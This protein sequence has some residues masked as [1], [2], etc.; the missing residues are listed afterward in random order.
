MASVQNDWLMCWSLR[1]K[2]TRSLV[3]DPTR[4]AAALT[5]ATG[6]PY[7]GQHLPIT[8]IRF[9]RNEGAIQFEVNVPTDA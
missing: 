3:F 2:K 9:V 6:L 7:D 5:A 1:S 4:L 8:V